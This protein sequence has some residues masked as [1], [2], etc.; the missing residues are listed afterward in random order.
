[1][2]EHRLGPQIHPV[3]TVIGL[4]EVRQFLAGNA[5]EH[6]G[7]GFEQ[8]YLDTQFGQHRR[9]LKPDVA[10]ADHHRG[11]GSGIERRH[12]PVGIGTG[13]DREDSGKIGPG[14]AQLAGIAAGCP[15]QLAVADA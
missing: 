12:Q 10:A 14:A 13:A 6:P 15:D 9:R 11:L 3:R 5:G 8:R 2:I 1:M 7:Q 4:V